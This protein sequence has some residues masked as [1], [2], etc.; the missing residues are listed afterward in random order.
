M[1]S[2]SVQIS[3]EYEEDRH[4]LDRVYAVPDREES[5]AHLVT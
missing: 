3:A 4:H 1:I 5:E 2:E